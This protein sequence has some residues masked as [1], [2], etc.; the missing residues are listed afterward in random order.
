MLFPPRIKRGSAM[1]PSPHY[2]WMMTV[3]DNACGLRSNFLSLSWTPEWEKKENSKIGRLEDTIMTIT[4]TL[5][6]VI[7]PT[8]QLAI[9]AWQFPPREPW[10]AGD[11]P[12]EEGKAGGRKKKAFEQD[13]GTCLDHQDYQ[14]C[15]VAIARLP[16]F[17]GKV[18]GAPY[19]LYT[20]TLYRRI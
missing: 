2:L 5:Y 16:I 17:G 1:Y 13:P 8:W 7:I 20:L 4:N 3:D 6:L 15:Q 12:H 14:V 11:H 19:V 18:P 9:P 10:R